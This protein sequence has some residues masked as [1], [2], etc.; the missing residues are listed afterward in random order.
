MDN[1]YNDR[2]LAFVGRATPYV[3]Y[4][5]CNGGLEK[6][7]GPIRWLTNLIMRHTGAG[8]KV[9]KNMEADVVKPLTRLN[10]DLGKLRSTYKDSRIAAIK[11]VDSKGKEV[12]IGQNYLDARAAME[13]INK[14]LAANSKIAGAE[15]QD[16]VTKLKAVHASGDL[17]KSKALLNSGL[18]DSSGLSMADDLSKLLGSIKVKP[19]TNI[20]TSDMNKIKAALGYKKGVTSLRNDAFGINEG[21]MS[22]YLRGLEKSVSKDVNNPITKAHTAFTDASNNA[23]RTARVYDDSVRGV[24]NQADIAKLG[25]NGGIYGKKGLKAMSD[26]SNLYNKYRGRA[27]AGTTAAAAVPAAAGAYAWG[28]SNGAE[29]G[30]EQFKQQQLPGMLQ[31]A[32]S[33]GHSYAQQQANNAGFLDRLGYLFTGNNSSLGMTNPLAGSGFGHSSNPT[34]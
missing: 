30:V 12:G 9:I 13:A 19:N 31:N 34:V 3:D 8:Q 32:A 29:N 1:N 28:S 26:Y 20:K 25:E 17:W 7:A 11:G 6:S 14:K 18:K 10:E 27:I 16:L 23:V 21:N 22:E 24:Y 2:V 33:V 15:W 5:G 4:I